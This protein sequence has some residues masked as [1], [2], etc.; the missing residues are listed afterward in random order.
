MFNVLFQRADMFLNRLQ[1]VIVGHEGD[2]L[3]GTDTLPVSTDK[4][5][6][7][8]KMASDERFFEEPSEFISADLSAFRYSGGKDLKVGA[9]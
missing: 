8:T 7:G 6:S 2:I 4:T 1:P 9:P 5:R 3:H